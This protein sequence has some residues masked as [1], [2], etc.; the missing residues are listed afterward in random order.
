MGQFSRVADFMTPDPHAIELHHSLA[1]AERRM[2]E[3]RVR[4]LPVLYQG[5]L[6]GTIS[7]RDVALV[8]SL[9]LDP[10][11]VGIAETLTFEPYTVSAEAPLGRVVRAMAAHRYGCAVVLQDGKVRGIFTATDAMRALALLIDRYEPDQ[12][13]LSALEIREL[14][15]SEHLHLRQLIAHALDNARNVCAGETHEQDIR[16]MRNAARSVCTALIAH[17]EL[18]DRL[19]AP[20]LE[21][22]D[23]WGPV[24][25]SQLRREHA[26]QRLG[27]DRALLIL[28]DETQAVLAQAASIED[29]L[30]QIQE[31]I[32]Q[33][34][35]ELL[36]S[37]VLKEELVAAS[38]EGG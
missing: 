6:R 11:E 9:E 4:Q 25:A 17:T 35:T 15:L 8:R 22:I 34:E 27:L 1:E 38:A 18:E 36:G 31:D 21:T 10:R 16:A 5:T 24:R 30:R 19:L 37:D 3:L 2:K 7:E 26:R 28:E 12:E 32:A 20:L 29:L 13:Q 23:A 33:E 14:V